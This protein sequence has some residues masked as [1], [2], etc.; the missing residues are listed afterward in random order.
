MT[1]IADQLAD[2]LEDA[3]EHL[4]DAGKRYIASQLEIQLAAYN[5]AQKAEGEDARELVIEAWAAIRDARK[6]LSSTTGN[7]KAVTNALLALRIKDDP[8]RLTPPPAPAVAAEAGQVAAVQTLQ[9][10]GYTWRG[11]E[12]WAPPIGKRPDF[13]L[14]DRLKAE[15][16]DARS[17]LAATQPA[18]PLSRAQAERIV[19]A[20]DQSDGGRDELATFIWALAGIQPAGNGKAG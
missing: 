2:A 4:K 6:W 20:L 17:A 12:L 13:N 15:R 18:Q 5:S 16:D 3:I 14:I 8:G 10:L 11:G 1:T 7:A 19:S 9:R